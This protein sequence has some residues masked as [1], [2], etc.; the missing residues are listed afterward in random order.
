VGGLGETLA[1][2]FVPALCA[3]CGE[4]LSWHGSRAG[5]C[6]ACWS[7]VELQRT[8]GCPRCG[9]PE[10]DAGQACLDCLDEPPVW[11][12]AASCGPYR[13]VLRDLVLHFKTRGGDDL[14]RPLAELLHQRWQ[15]AGWPRPDLVTSV[16]IALLRRLRRGYNQAD[17]LGRRVARALDVEYANTLRRRHGTAQAG[18]SRTA[19]LSL[20][21]GAFRPRRTLA[22]AVLLVDDVMTTGATAAACTR[23]LL[24]AGADAVDVLTLART[25]RAGRMP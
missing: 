4:A 20:R 23:A 12:A 21:S 2:T 6:A 25:E 24:A 11:R 9:N 8:N 18:R 16:P 5:G 15:K 14:D 13:G 7:G 22:G 1:A 17:L 19:R 3:C 10:V